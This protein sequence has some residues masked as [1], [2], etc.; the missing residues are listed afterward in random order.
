MLSLVFLVSNFI[1]I[2]L[3]GLTIIACVLLIGYPETQLNYAL[4]MGLWASPFLLISLIGIIR[5]RRI[6]PHSGPQRAAA[7]HDDFDDPGQDKQ[8]ND[9]PDWRS[10]PAMDSWAQ[11]LN[12]DRLGTHKPLF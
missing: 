11:R 2:G 1:S 10:S 12:D 7:A 5:F 4:V 8:Q 3:I 9:Q 6:D